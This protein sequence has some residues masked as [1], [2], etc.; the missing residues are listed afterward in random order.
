MLRRIKKILVKKPAPTFNKSADVLQ[1]DR[2]ISLGKR[3]VAIANYL[4]KYFSSTVAYGPLKGFRFD[5]KTWWNQKDRGGMLLGLY[6]QEVLNALTKLPTT[7]RTFIDLGAADGYYGVGALINNL[8]DESYC[9]E[10]SEQGQAVIRANAELNHVQ[11]RVH[12]YGKADIDFYRIIPAEKRAT[13]VLLIDIEGGEF[14]LL[15]DDVLREFKNAVIIVELHPWLVAN[16]ETGLQQL[17][18]RAAKYFTLTE[19]KTS[20]RDSSQFPVLQ[21][22]SDDNRW[23]V[24]SEGRQ[25]LMSWLRLDPKK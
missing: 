17:K 3:R 2:K 21:N 19:F 12:I 7:H 8:F 20:A 9:F 24:C 4:D 1:L 14:D 25:R 11:D 15:T 5:P 16:G 6:E 23:L 22:F 13:S 18:A 10:M